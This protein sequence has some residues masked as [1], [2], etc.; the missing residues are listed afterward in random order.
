MR[1]FLILFILTSYSLFAQKT[2]EDFGYKHLI[3][4]YENKNVN[5]IIKSKLGDEEKPKPLFFWCQG[6]LPQPVIK[7]DEN[8]EYGTFPFKATDFL[9]QYHLI[10][11]GKPGIPI[12]SNVKDLKANYTFEDKNHTI[13]EEYTDQNYLDFYVKRNNFILKKLSKEKWVTSEKLVV[14]GHSE[15]S[16]IATKMAFTNR[17]TT[18]LIISGGNPYGRILSVLA[19]SRY[20]N[21]DNST[22][23][24]WRRVVENK[25]DLNPKEG[26]SYKCTF[27]FSIDITPIIKKLKI[28]VLI[29]YGT[30]DWSTP[31]NDMFYVETIKNNLKNITFTP[32]T[33]LE[34]NYFPVNEKLEANQEI[35]NWENVGK[36]WIKWLDT[37]K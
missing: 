36:N 29:S 4:Q 20:E 24:Y 28:P 11:I 30:K 7:Y 2:P 14:A 3:F 15:G 18:Q 8:G 9:D 33:G 12:I 34:H 26:D 6:S 17:K 10:I 16:Y 21:D 22:I 27:D 35:Y 32:Y 19:Q 25:N 13:P 37:N 5:V 1:F 23:E 31:Y